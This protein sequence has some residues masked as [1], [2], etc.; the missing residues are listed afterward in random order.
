MAKPARPT[1]RRP[2]ASRSFADA[3]E[4]MARN[5]ELVIKGKDEVNRTT[6]KTQSALLEAMAERTVTV[7]GVSHQLPRPFLVLATQN[8]IELAGTF[9]LPEA[10]LDRFLFRLAM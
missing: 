4:A 9:P 7:D 5:V 10:Q 1:R 6:P 8:P 2:D 3:F